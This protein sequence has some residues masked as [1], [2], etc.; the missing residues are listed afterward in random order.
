MRKADD[1]SGMMSAISEAWTIMTKNMSMSYDDVGKVFEKW[2]TE[3]ELV[4]LY[5][6]L[7][8]LCP[9]NLRRKTHSS[10][11]SAPTSAKPKTST[12]NTSSATSK[13]R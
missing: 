8:A 13:I 4:S 12:A 11:K 1:N 9:T 7:F 6:F 3:G 10:S 5:T 2:S